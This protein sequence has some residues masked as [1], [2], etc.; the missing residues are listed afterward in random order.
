MEEVRRKVRSRQVISFYSTSTPVEDQPGM[1]TGYIYIITDDN[2]EI[3]YFQALVPIAKIDFDNR[4][5]ALETALAE[6]WFE[7]PQDVEYRPA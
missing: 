7:F 3:T 5:A 4:F 2:A 1:V 6:T